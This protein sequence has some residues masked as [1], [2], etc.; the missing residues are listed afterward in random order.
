MVK[1]DFLLNINPEIQLNKT[2]KTL[3]R[4][5]SLKDSNAFLF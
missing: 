4:S 2:N 5:H 3:K 1:S